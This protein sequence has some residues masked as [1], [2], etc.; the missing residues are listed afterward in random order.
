MQYELKNPIVIGDE[1]I[2]NVDIK[3]KWSAGDFIDVQN[4][5]EGRGD[6]ACRQ[7][8]IA[9]GKPDLVVRKMSIGD[10]K[11]ILKISNDFFNASSEQEKGN[12]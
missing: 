12:T 8:S 4:A 9:I 5:G 6:L 10:Y 7:V 1:T 11:E 3:E 2:R